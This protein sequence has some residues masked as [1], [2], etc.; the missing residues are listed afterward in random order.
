MTGVQTCAV[1]RSVCIGYLVYR[2]LY[3]LNHSSVYATVASWVLY[4]AEIWGTTSLLLF[5]MQ[6]W[7]PSEPPEQ[8]PL[9]EGEVDVFVPDR[10]RVVSGQRVDLGAR[11][12]IHK[13]N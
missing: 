5:L 2:G 11:R 4:L 1:F 8:P 9:E 7:D 6:V 12:L 3:T 13:Q 10:K